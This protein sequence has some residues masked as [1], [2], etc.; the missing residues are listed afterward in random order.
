MGILKLFFHHNYSLP[1]PGSV[2]H[3]RHVRKTDRVI[4]VTEHYEQTLTLLLFM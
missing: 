3:K 4:L 1:L 2:V